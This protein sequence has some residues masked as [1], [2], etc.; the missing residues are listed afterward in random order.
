LLYHFRKYAS[1]HNSVSNALSQSLAYTTPALIVS[2][3]SLSAG[4]LIIAFSR[5]PAVADF[6]AL[7]VFAVLVALATD[8]LLLPALI[9]RFW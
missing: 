6:G 8:L 1:Q 7:C 2:S 5:T 9:R 4:F 3:I